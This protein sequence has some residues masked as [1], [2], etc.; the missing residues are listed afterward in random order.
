MTTQIRLL[1]RT[2]VERFCRI[3]HS[4]IYRLMREGQFPAA[5]RTE[6]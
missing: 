3:G 1:Y 6:S 4:T 5:I 2:V